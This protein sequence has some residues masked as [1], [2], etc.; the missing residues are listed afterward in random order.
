MATYTLI[1][2]FGPEDNVLAIAPPYVLTGGYP[3]LLQIEDENIAVRGGAGTALISVD[4]GV[5]GTTKAAHA[6]GTT[7]DDIPPLTA[8]G[9]SSGILKAT[10]TLS[11]A[12]IL[13]LH[14]TPVTLVAAPGAGKT[15]DVHRVLLQF[16]FGTTQY[17]TTD[18]TGIG[19]T[20]AGAGD[21]SLG[22][23]G[24]LTLAESLD[25]SY[26]VNEFG[27]IPADITN[28]ALQVCAPNGSTVFTDGDGTLTVN[29]WYSVE[30]VPA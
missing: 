1:G 6:S 10:V 13:A 30:D 25:I 2:D 21:M 8:S 16:R 12:Q 3:A 9:E 26:A 4:R 7:L 20:F 29:V 22:S 28:K 14:T 5:D 17:A 23:T 18:L 24:D 19:L 15:I 27:G 11:S